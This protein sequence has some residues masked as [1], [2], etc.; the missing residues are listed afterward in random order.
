[1]NSKKETKP[2]KTELRKHLG[3]KNFDRFNRILERVINPQKKP[4]K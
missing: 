2:T 3:N 1:M 4:Q